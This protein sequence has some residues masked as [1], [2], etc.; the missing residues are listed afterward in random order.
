MYTRNA[1]SWQCNDAYILAR[2]TDF[3]IGIRTFPLHIFSPDIS[4]LGKFPPP[5]YMTYDIPP[6]HF[7]RTFCQPCIYLRIVHFTNVKGG[8]V[9]D[10][11]RNCS[12][13]NLSRGKCSTLSASYILVLQSAAKTKLQL[14]SLYDASDN[15]LFNSIAVWNRHYPPPITS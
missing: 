8:N 4:P 14:F 3:C 13:G 6:H 5:L 10:G 2:T 7:K 9:L 11:E 15:Q 1:A 12:R